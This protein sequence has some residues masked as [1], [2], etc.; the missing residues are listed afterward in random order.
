MRFPG[1]PV[2]LKPHQLGQ[3]TY[4][5]GWGVFSWVHVS[6][7][8]KSELAECLQNGQHGWGGK[9][10]VSFSDAQI[11]QVLLAVL[12]QVALSASFPCATSQL[13]QP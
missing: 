6:E 3:N 8:G 10:S 9:L 7:N 4:W 1:S 13:S 11:L 2:H 5:G 12:L